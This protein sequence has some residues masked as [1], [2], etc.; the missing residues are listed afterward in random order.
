M[1][2]DRMYKV[3]TNSTPTTKRLFKAG[4]RNQVESTLT[5][6]TWTIEPADAVETADLI[7][8]GVKVEA[9]KAAEKATADT[10]AK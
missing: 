4:T 2:T 3:T 6:E 5:A 10:A 1:A 9:V 7:A 8:S